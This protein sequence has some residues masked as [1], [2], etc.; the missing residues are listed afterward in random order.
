[1]TALE[2]AVARFLALP[3]V[4]GAV[5]CSDTQRFG[6]AR[7]E[8]VTDPPSTLEPAPFAQPPAASAPL[9]GRQ[10]RWRSPRTTGEDL[11]GIGGTSDEDIWLV[12]RAGTILHWDGK[13][14]SVPYEAPADAALSGVWTSGPSDVWIFGERAN[15]SYVLRWDGSTWAEHFGLLGQKIRTVGSGATSRLI[16]V[17]EGVVDPVREYLPAEGSWSELRTTVAGDPTDVWIDASDNAWVS[18]RRSRAVARCARDQTVRC[19]ALEIPALAGAAEVDMFGIWGTDGSD[20]DV[21]YTGIP[22]SPESVGMFHFDGATWSKRPEE[23]SVRRSQR[24]PTGFH[25]PPSGTIDR[26]RIAA[27]FDGTFVTY[28]P[29]ALRSEASSP[30]ISENGKA[31]ASELWGATY[32]GWA[33]AS[34]ARYMAGPLGMFVRLDSVDRPT[35]LLPFVEGHLGRVTVSS[36]GVAYSHAG[37][38]ILDWTGERWHATASGTPVV[39]T[40]GSTNALWVSADAAFGIGRWNGSVIEGRSCCAAAARDLWIGPDRAWAAVPDAAPADGD[41]T[42]SGEVCHRPLEGDP[43]WTCVA[44][45]RAVRAISGASADDVWL[46]GD[47]VFRW[48]GHALVAAPQFR[49]RTTGFEG[50]LARGA[51]DVWLWGKASFHFDGRTSTP[52]GEALGTSPDFGNGNI[53]SVVGD[54]AGDLYFLVGAAASASP[55]MRPRASKIYRYR[56]DT[57]VLELDRAVEAPLRHLSAYGTEVWATGD[58]GVTM[59]LTVGPTTPSEQ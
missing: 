10:W 18:F 5:A 25:M 48:N 40:A 54:A 52:A 50:V 55:S 53:L 41:P 14:L 9:R 51:N 28:T 39:T 36:A 27:F 2:Q 58:H 31:T 34:G 56:A 4:L 6:S 1:M 57:H 59:S 23:S 32:A 45:E 47:G 11:L 44:T 49:G 33:S 17:L 12:G 37:N 19:S 13:A 38:A 35:S 16:V 15:A 30:A 43:A 24:A 42:W 46:V 7:V 29:L 26:R 22:G 8:S 21:F 20:V 3:C